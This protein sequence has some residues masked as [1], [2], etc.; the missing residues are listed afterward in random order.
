MDE[1]FPSKHIKRTSSIQSKGYV[2][3]E[4][5]NDKEYLNLMLSNNMYLIDDLYVN[6]C[7]KVVQVCVD[8][9]IQEEALSR[10]EA[11]M[12]LVTEKDEDIQMRIE[13][14]DTEYS[15]VKSEIT[16]LKQIIKD[17]IETS[18]RAKG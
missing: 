1:K 8:E 5:V 16:S 6:S 15:A 2:H 11:Q 4:K 3:Q 10:Y 12:A 14:L 17:N 9:S 18:F 13:A 7:A